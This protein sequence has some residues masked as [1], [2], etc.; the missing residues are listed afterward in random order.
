MA[1]VFYAGDSYRQQQWNKYHRYTTTYIIMPN[2]LKGRAHAT[3]QQPFCMLQLPV[4]QDTLLIPHSSMVKL[5]W[6][7]T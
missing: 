3:T 5:L 7:I 4:T 6:H 2:I 1:C